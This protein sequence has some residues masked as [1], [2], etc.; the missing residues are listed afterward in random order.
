M[1]TKEWLEERMVALDREKVQFLAHLNANAGKML[2]IE[3]ML[4][5]LEEGEKDDRPRGDET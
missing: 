1:I 2:L 5:K 4:A 3:E